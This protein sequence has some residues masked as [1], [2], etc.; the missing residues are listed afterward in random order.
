MTVFAGFIGNT[1]LL[2]GALPPAKALDQ[3][4]RGIESRYGMGTADMVAMQLEYPRHG[5]PR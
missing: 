1:R 3:A 4:R 2:D 5:E